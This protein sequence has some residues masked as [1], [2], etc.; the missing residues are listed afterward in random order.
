MTPVTE[1]P[2]LRAFLTDPTDPF[3][4]IEHRHEIW[5]DDPFDVESIH[6]DARSTF[7]RML[8]RATTPPGLRSGRILVL[9]GA[10]GAGKTHL[11][12][13]FRRYVHG[14]HAGFFA[15][16]QMTSK[17][18]NYGRYVLRNV[19]DSLDQPYDEALDTRSGLV[20]VADV[21][22]SRALDEDARARL[23]E[24]PDLEGGEVV[25]IVF[26]AADRLLSQD[27]HRRA[28]LDLLRAL[29]F[30]HRQDSKLK[31]RVLKYLRCEDY[32]PADRKLLGGIA[33]RKAEDD[34]QRTLEM[35][36]QILW[37]LG[38]QALVV[39]LD[40]LE[41]MYDVDQ[42]ERHFRVAMDTVADLAD[43]VP[44]S[45]V[46]VSCLDDYY[47]KLKE[48]LPPPLQHRLE[49]DP[50]P[51]QLGSP[52]TTE[53]IREIV[54]ARMRY[55]YTNAGVAPVES[56]PAYPFPEWF[57]DEM[58]NEGTRS[59]IDACQRYRQ[60][61]CALGRLLHQ[62]DDLSTTTDAGARRAKEAAITET[63]QLWNDHLARNETSPPDGDDGLAELLAWAI[64]SCGEELESGLQFEATLSANNVD[65]TAHLPGGGQ[66]Q[67]FVA[68]CNSKPQGNGLQNQITA[69][70]EKGVGRTLVLVRSSEFPKKAKT[71][72]VKT[73]AG[74]LA[75]GA[76]TMVPIDADLRT[77]LALRAFRT[78]HQ[79]RPFFREWLMGENHL[80]RLFTMRGILDLD[81]LDRPVVPNRLKPEPVR[82][83]E[84]PPAGGD[85]PAALIVVP[86]PPTSQK[87]SV[88]LSGELN[89]QPVELEPHELIR[90]AAFLGAPGSGKTTL[91]LNILEQ[92]LVQGIPAVLIDRKG[93]LAGYA[94]GDA[95]TRALD[96]SA[97]RGRQQ[98]LRERLD[99]ALFTP[100]HPEGRAIAMSI[101]PEGI[102]AM[103][104]IERERAAQ[105]AAHALA[106]MLSYK[107]V[108]KDKSLRAVLVQAFQ[109][110]ATYPAKM[111]LSLPS[112]VRL[113]DS[114]D[115]A[116]V[117]AIGKLDTKLFARLIQDLETLRISSPDLFAAEG[118]KL[119]VDLLFGK[120][121]YAVPGKTRLSVV[122]TK[123]LNGNDRVQFWVAQLLMGVSRWMSANPSTALQA[124]LF[125]DEADMYLP[126]IGQPPTKGP[127][128]DLLKRARS[129]GLGLMIATQSPGDLDYK[130]RDSI[131]SW[132]VGQVRETTAINKLKPM[133]SE[134]TVDVSSKLP[135]QKPGEFFLIRD[136]KVTG[137]R[138]SR[139]L[140]ATE[141]LAE[142]ELL[143]LAKSRRPEHLHG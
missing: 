48:R 28:D 58:T 126:A 35:L 83:A 5:S 95:F 40:Q 133:L 137:M 59:V 111:E 67:C 125:L 36:G 134:C 24:A 14:G 6:E 19:I 11:L 9:R 117:T 102:G 70:V 37:S 119:D 30:L 84:K 81:R 8:L 33:P 57:L 86:P 140:L 4:P 44:S 113:L 66:E 100:G 90:H 7:Q 61:S 23:Q 129:A 115:E 2:R 99:V 101:A 31:S 135:G 3:H 106:S 17:V 32:P 29:L 138:S 75:K 47:C 26:D 76:R 71:A 51:I 142:P 25:R 43:R 93:D 54:A 60:R 114:Q 62:G 94:K 112:L 141:Q 56:E 118:E 68:V 89:P 21:L 65:V 16:M 18:D 42:S 10:A 143:A 107:A 104:P 63:E 131:R 49:Q 87:L 74:V 46:V 64:A 12:R 92:V 123:F 27:R 20:R 124:I 80:S 15:Y 53:E 78:G 50:E 39:C 139:S 103:A 136:G 122:S 110:L 128:E 116:L 13:A 55:L 22:A 85:T 69:A 105:H 79:S 38:D 88:G 109:L 91:A 127:M 108:G 45:I 72:I 1:N 52:R 82:S 41:G 132:F 98:L 34:P 96:D 130:C 121:R 73:I 77:M 97:L 120:G